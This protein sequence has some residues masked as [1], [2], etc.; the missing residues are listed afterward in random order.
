QLKSSATAT[1]KVASNAPLRSPVARDDFVD[2]ADVMDPETQHV[3][4]DVLANDC[5]PDGSTNDLEGE[6]DGSYEGVELRGA[7]ATVRIVP[8]DAQERLRYT[9]TDVDG[10]EPAGYSWVP[11]T[12]KQTPV[13]VVDPLT[14]Q[15][16]SE[17][18]IDL[19]DPN[20][21]RVRPG[22]EPVQITDPD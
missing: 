8:Q 11:G 22:A 9:I 2:A 13:W 12:A 5:D 16:G 14:V 18:T 3:A 7:D 6:I 15:A 20:N 17:G 1:I 21:V 19:A 4:V 10:L